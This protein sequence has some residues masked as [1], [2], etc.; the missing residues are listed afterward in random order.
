M[1]HARPPFRRGRPFRGFTL[2][3]S[4]ATIVVLGAIG[5]V[6]S[7]TIVTAANGFLKATT[8]GQM[9]IELSVTL[10]RAVRE[11][12]RIP[13]DAAASGI[14]PDIDS[15]T[16]TSI[17]WSGNSSLSLSGTNLMLTINGGTAAVLQTNVSSFSVQAF[18]ESNTALGATLSTTGCDPIRRILLTI[19]V[20][21][22]SISETLRARVFLRS[23]M[24]G[25]GS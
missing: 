11:I 16:A 9:N 10:D 3:E 5:M 1:T 18:N 2:I 4:I 23:T 8:A 17:A 6:A 15:V 13:L 7:S 21:R 20:T 14:A 25:A 12:R 24:S 19:T 22:D